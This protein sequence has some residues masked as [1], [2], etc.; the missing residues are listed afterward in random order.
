MGKYIVKFFK[1]EKVKYVS[2]LDTVRMFGRTMRRAGITMSMSQGFNPHPIMT[3]AN[4]IGIGI[5]STCE[6]A[7]IGVDEEISPKELAT[8]LN[9]HLPS[10]FKVLAAKKEFAKSPFTALHFAQYKMTVSGNI[11]NPATILD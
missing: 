1:D 2:H 7:L 4:P 5:S 9:E 8:T 3:F 11:A 6:L 10:G